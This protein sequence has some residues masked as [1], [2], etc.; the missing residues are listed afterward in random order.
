M[1]EHPII[2]YWHIRF[3]V[4]INTLLIVTGSFK[5]Y[6][7]RNIAKRHVKIE[8]CIMCHTANKAYYVKVIEACRKTV[9][10]MSQS[11]CINTYIKYVNEKSHKKIVS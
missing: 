11:T 4:L 2:T 10:V 8:I 6:L 7:Q 3:P 5:F 1:F 9:F